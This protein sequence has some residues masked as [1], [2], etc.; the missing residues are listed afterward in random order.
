MSRPDLRL[1]LQQAYE[2]V[3]ELELQAFKPGNVSVYSEGHGMTVEHFR[4][5]AAASSVALADPSLSVGEKI[6]AAARA[7]WSVVDCNTNLGILL[8]CAPLIQ[9]VQQPCGGSLRE[10]L[11]A[12]LRNTT[13]AD[14]EAVYEAIRLASPGG[15]GEAPRQDVRESPQVTLV[16]AMALA[17]E[18]DRIAYQYVSG[19][20]DI[21]DFAI[22]RYHTSRRLGKDEAWVAVEIFAGLL[23]RIP[24]SHIERK[25]GGRYTRMVAERMALVDESLFEAD[26]PDRCMALL[27]EV[28]AEFK[29]AG[30]NP[31]TT[32][33]LTVAGLLAVRLCVLFENYN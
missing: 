16:E 29:T 2:E 9:A 15:L 10:S 32:A 14:A 28:D 25:F 22:P 21:F 27:R 5:S 20:I 17:A 18:R 3:C 11:S 19:Y 23:R 4:R 30:V 7:T 31:G 12:V 8:L 26:G 1:A 13:R 24:D 6:L 33:D